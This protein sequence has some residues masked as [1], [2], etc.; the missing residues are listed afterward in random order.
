MDSYTLVIYL[1]GIVIISYLYNIIS[2]KIRVPSV[3]LL[4]GTG[5]FLRNFFD[6]KFLPF[7]VI[8]R[9]VETL[10]IIGLIMIILEA[11]LDLNIRKDK[12]LM[13]GKAFFSALIILIVSSFFIAYMMNYMLKEPFVNCLIYAV[14]L[15]IV[16]SAIV[17]PS[18][19]M[20]TP[21]S[22]EFIIYEASFSDILGILLFNYLISVEQFTP[23][24]GVIY[25]GKI[26]LGSVLSFIVALI[27]I[28]LLS[29][30]T[31]HVK[32][33]LMF[34]VLIAL[35][36]IG[37]LLQLP[38][39]IIILL[40][41]LLVNNPSLIRP[42]KLLNYINIDAFRKLGEQLKDITAE[43]SFIVR[44]FFFLLFGYSINTSVLIEK[45][46]LVIGTMIVLL[47]LLVRFTFLKYLNPKQN[48]LPE[49]LIMPRGLITILL[50]Y[51]IPEANTLV[52]FNQGI[53]FYVILVTSFLM[54]IGLLVTKQ[55]VVEEVESSDHHL[56]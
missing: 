17:L 24:S 54:M 50:F 15:S 14:P 21:E 41:G 52:N 4:L 13:I 11:A 53:L 34:A 42:K 25:G 6:G 18:V 3:L 9:G 32:F 23:L 37:K 2:R 30:I 33:F 40:F 44:T 19:D 7:D 16:S 39:L 5:I 22:K 46:V 26:V 28:Y 35:Y 45:D 43:T 1:T 51:N 20:L 8:S 29:K 10:G 49:L 12:L 31:L 38:S 56:M 48:P 55:E 47:L 27:L 36:T